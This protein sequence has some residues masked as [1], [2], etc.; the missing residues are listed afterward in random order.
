MKDAL[1]TGM[2]IIKC[3]W[4]RKEDYTPFVQMMNVRAFQEL[5]LQDVQI[6]KVEGPDALGSLTVTYLSPYYVKNAPVIENILVS[7]LL[8]SADA[9][10]LDEANF[11]AHKKKVTMSYLREREQD[12][13]YANVD[14]I[15]PK[16]DG[17]RYSG[18][19]YR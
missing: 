16:H 5:M 2:G 6:V 15:K 7:E 4:E 9:K 1:I 11:V 3:Y 8:Y 10:T 19:C 12:G 17:C 13:I 14:D 18:R